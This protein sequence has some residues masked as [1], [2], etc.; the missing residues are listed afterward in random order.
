MYEVW[1][2]I[3]FDKGEEIERRETFVSYLDGNPSFALGFTWNLSDIR[4]TLIYDSE[5]D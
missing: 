1:S 4:I 2:S 3:K 5:A